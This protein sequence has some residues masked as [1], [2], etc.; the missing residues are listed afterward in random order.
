MSNEHRFKAWNILDTALNRQSNGHHYWEAKAL[1]D[2]LLHRGEKV[3]LFTHRNAPAAERFPGVEIVPT[4][5]L[6]LWD[7]TLERSHMV[8][9]ENFIVHTRTFHSD[10]LALEPS[11]FHHS[12]TLFPTLREIQLLG[13]F[14]WLGDLA[15]EIRPKAAV[16]L[17]SQRSWAEL[18][19]KLYKTLW[20]NCAPELKRDIALFCRT[21]M[22]AEWTNKH[23]GI[24]AGVLP[25]LAPAEVLASRQRSA[26]TT[27]G[28]MVVSFVGGGRQ[29][30]GGALIGDVVEQCAASG[31]RF[32]I[33]AKHESVGAEEGPLAGLARWPHV[34][35]QL[36]RA[37][38]GRVLPGDRGRRGAARL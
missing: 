25:F 15:Q 35:V 7:S 11:L 8:R 10:L 29:E 34:Q 18:S 22:A 12:V 28:P 23:T 17:T 33:Q 31:V 6:D 37:G 5:A 24:A 38:T 4:F 20:D 16:C 27:E 1:V 13:L 14:R 9:V 21:P 26:E 36:G 19:A 32:F 2:E 3:R 30:Q